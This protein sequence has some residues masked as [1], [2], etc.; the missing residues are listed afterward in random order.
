[1]EIHR[2][3]AGVQRV[4][5]GGLPAW[6]SIGALQGLQRVWSSSIFSHSGTGSLIRD[7][8]YI[9]TMEYYISDM[10]RP[11]MFTSWLESI[12]ISKTDAEYAVSRMRELPSEQTRGFPFWLCIQPLV[13]L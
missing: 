6:K 2:C 12:Q 4:W 10:S 5:C 8:Y 3:P 7:L 1:M 11:E 9:K 13:V